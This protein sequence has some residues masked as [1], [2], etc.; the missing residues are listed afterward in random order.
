MEDTNDPL[1]TNVMVIQSDIIPPSLNQLKKDLLPLI[2]NLSGVIRCPICL[3]TKRDF[4]QLKCSHMFCKECTSR[5]VTMRQ[6]RC[7]LC[8]RP[9][10][11]RQVTECHAPISSIVDIIDAVSSVLQDRKES[12]EELARQREKQ[13]LEEERMMTRQIRRC[14]LCPRGDTSREFSNVDFGETIQLHG[15]TIERS[16]GVWAHRICGLY[17]HGVKEVDGKL[18]YVKSAITR[19]KKRVCNRKQCG[20]RRANVQCAVSNCRINYHYPCAVLDEDVTLDARGRL[21][22]PAHANHR[23]IDEAAPLPFPGHNSH[24]ASC[25]I[26]RKQANDSS[27]LHCT[28]CG[29]IAHSQCIG[30]PLTKQWICTECA[31]RKTEVVDIVEQE[32]DMRPDTGK[33][34]RPEKHTVPDP[35]PDASLDSEEEEEDEVED[36]IEA[37]DIY[38]SDIQE[39]PRKRLRLSMKSGDVGIQMIAHTGLDDR[40]KARLERICKNLGSSIQGTINPTV[41]VVVIGARNRHE[42]PKRT[43]KLCQAV[44][45]KIDIVFFS[46]AEESGRNGSF[47]PT[48]SFLHSIS[49]P[50]DQGHVFEGLKVCFGFYDGTPDMKQ[51]LMHL[52]AL[53]KGEV[54]PRPLSKAQEESMTDV[55]YV[56]DTVQGSGGRKRNVRSRYDPPLT[57]T[58]VASAWLLDSCVKSQA[59]H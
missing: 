3:E 17:T 4:A 56:K 1:S 13:R 25:Y 35:R 37:T 14:I 8:M 9:T 18:R 54:L 55:L 33:R 52:V 29:R 11:K 30:D 32:D 15:H 45:A 50:K 16:G 48:E 42:I 43:M 57:G 10:S 26:C 46:W 51:S 34:I 24:E 53:G 47:Y 2:D 39:V 59:S 20:K 36:E 41:Q 31:P 12:D 58:V 7:A 49:W 28:S 21:F 5:L 38:E 44:A 6:P 40:R 19:C 22:C 23:L 27:L